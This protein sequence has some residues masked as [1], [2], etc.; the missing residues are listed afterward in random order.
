MSKKRVLFLCIG[1]I[2]PSPMAEAFARKYG[3]DVIEPSSAGLFPALSTHPMTRSV[4][5]EKNVDLGDHIP[6]RFRDLDPNKYDLIVNISGEELPSTPS[7]PVENWN[8]KDPIG[9]DQDEFRRA[10]E[11]LEMLVMRLIL[12]I[13]TGKFDL[14]MKSRQQ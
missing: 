5:R 14:A 1:N 7:V 6:R 8:V 4:L 9:G 13:R 12:R 3:S 10:M 2:C 11:E